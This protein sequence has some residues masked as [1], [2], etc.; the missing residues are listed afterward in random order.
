MLKP[1][2][3]SLSVEGETYNYILTKIPAIP[4]REIVT[5]YVS[6]IPKIGSKYKVSHRTMLKLMSYV[7]VVK[8]DHKIQLVSEELINNHVTD[9]EALCRIEI[10]MLEYNARF[11]RDGR[12]STFLSGIAQKLPQWISKTLTDSLEPLLRKEKQP[13]GN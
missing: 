12:A 3:F 5:K 6:S 8:G 11:F 2:D 13:S 9:W 1:K 4:A 7:Y 10:A